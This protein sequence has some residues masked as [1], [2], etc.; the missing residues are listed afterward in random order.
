MS[1]RFAYSS[2]YGFSVESDA[3]GFKTGAFDSIIAFSDDQVHY[4]VREHCKQAAIAKDMLYSLWYPWKDVRV[5]TFLKHSG[6]WHIRLHRITS[7]R[8]LWSTEGGFAAPRTD[9]DRD[10]RFVEGP[11][12]WVVS[13]LGDFSGIVDISQ[14]K[15]AARIV[16]PHGNTNVMFPRTLVP[17]LQASIKAHTSTTLACAVL[18]GPDADSLS[19]S[20]KSVPEMPSIEECNGLFRLSGREI[21][22]CR[23]E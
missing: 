21:E 11:S 20:F 16:T 5:E 8:D 10:Q 17:Q 13:E 14:P 12:A 1:R 6:K 18:A 4:R 3:L 7:S 23:D 2:R 19:S 22:V 9:F 15:R